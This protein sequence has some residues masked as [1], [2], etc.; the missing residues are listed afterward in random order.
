MEVN[1]PGME[2]VP[3]DGPG[4]SAAEVSFVIALASR[5]SRAAQNPKLEMPGD[6]LRV[7]LAL[8]SVLAVFAGVVRLPP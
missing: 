1:R 2:G 5:N 8:T 7:S 6:G 4:L 3:D